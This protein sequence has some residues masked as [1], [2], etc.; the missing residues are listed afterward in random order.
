MWYN[1]DEFGDTSVNGVPNGKSNCRRGDIEMDEEVMEE[2]MKR[3]IQTLEELE[4][5]LEE[6]K[7]DIRLLGKEEKNDGIRD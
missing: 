1:A 5:A 2:L 3:G 6:T 4:R 7:L